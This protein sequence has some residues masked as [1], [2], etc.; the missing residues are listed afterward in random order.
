MV[1]ENLKIS[2][3]HIPFIEFGDV[4]MCRLHLKIDFF[5]MMPVQYVEFVIYGAIRKSYGFWLLSSRKFLEISKSKS[6]IQTPSNFWWAC[7]YF[8]IMD[9][10]GNDS[11]R[12]D[13]LHN[14]R[15]LNATENFYKVV[16]QIS[17]QKTITF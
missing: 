16:I 1:Q 9:Q 7:R 11:E 14:R 3:I 10:N 5:E 17:R 12:F 6:F 13:T 15:S 8:E 2:K 4:N